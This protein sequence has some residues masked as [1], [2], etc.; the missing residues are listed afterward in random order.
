MEEKE[1]RQRV[2]P[3]QRRMYAMALKLGMPPDDAADAVQ[4]TQLKLWR[5]K[6]GIPDDSGG[7]TAY[8]LTALRN[9]CISFLRKKK[10]LSSLDSLNMV[11]I[12]PETVDIIEPQKRIE[13]L[14]D[15]LPEGQKKVIRLSSFG[16]YEIQEIS[17]AT[18]FTPGNVRQLLSRGRKRLRDLL[19]RET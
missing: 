17:E 7:L 2:M 10:E 11:G 12:E 16:G 8:C 13:I 1:F 18:G 15:T 14:I 19:N 6:A 3:L 9:E 4:E 5:G